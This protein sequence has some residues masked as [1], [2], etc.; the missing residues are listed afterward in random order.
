[1]T[2]IYLI[3]KSIGYDG[4]CYSLE[5]EREK[6]LDRIYKEELDCEAS[7]EI[8]HLTTA[9]KAIE[10]WINQNTNKENHNKKVLLT[11]ILDHCCFILYVMKEE[12]HWSKKVI[13]KMEHNLFNN[14]NSGKISLTESELIKALLL[15]NIVETKT[16]KEIKQISMSEELDLMERCNS[17]D[18][19]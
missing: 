18:L 11:N 1:M 8:W 3:L 7:C 14:L 4:E 16:V 9:R 15:H 10:K 17:Q 2:T 12:E 13:D 6:I 5:Y 19:I